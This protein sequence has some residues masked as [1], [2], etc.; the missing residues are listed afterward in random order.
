MNLNNPTKENLA[1]ILNELAERLSVANRSLMDPEDYDLAKYDEIKF[2]YDIV[3]QKGNFSAT[4]I[5]AF[6]EELRNV[7]K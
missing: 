7:R 6:I 5:H 1:F 2:M 4:E 3:V